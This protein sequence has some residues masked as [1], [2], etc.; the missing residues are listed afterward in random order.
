MVHNKTKKR[1][2]K[3]NKCK[4]HTYDFILFILGDTLQHAHCTKYKYLTEH[5]SKNEEKK[6][7]MG[8]YICVHIVLITIFLYWLK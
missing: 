7:Q 4:M 6:T 1:R 8:T 5:F 3:I 2:R